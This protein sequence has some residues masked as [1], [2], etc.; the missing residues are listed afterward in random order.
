M[1][2]AAHEK[3]EQHAEKYDAQHLALAGRINDVRGNRAKKYFDNVGNA[4]VADLLGYL[5]RIRLKSEQ[6]PCRFPVDDSGTHD[7]YQYQPHKYG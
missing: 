7:I 3:T 1:L 4:L 6:F 2:Q 5:A